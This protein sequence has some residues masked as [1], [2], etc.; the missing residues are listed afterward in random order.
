L[1]P[2]AGDPYDSQVD[3]TFDL[4]ERHHKTIGAGIGFQSD[5][6]LGL[7]ANWE[8]RNLLSQAE[9]L[10]LELLLAQQFQ[11]A[12][13]SFRKPHFLRDDQSLTLFSDLERERTDAFDS[14]SLEAGAEISRQFGNYLQGNIGAELT[15]S[16][17]EENNNSDNF[18]LASI[19]LSF[20]YDRRNDPLDPTSGWA[21]AVQLR[22]YLDAFSSGRQF[23][24]S[25]IAVS[26]YYTQ[27]HLKLRPTYAVRFAT[28]LINGEDRDD[29]PA[30]LRFFSG[31]G[32]SVRGYAFQSLGPF[33]DEDPAGG[34]SFTEISFESRLRIGANWGA[35]FFL[36][37][38]FAFTEQTPSAD[39]NI[40][41]GAGLGVRY[42]TNFAPIRF[43]IAAPLQPRGGVDDPFQIYISIGQSF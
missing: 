10:R 19:P 31:G 39:E 35:A 41:W 8:H 36:D 7:T 24:R 32:G 17:V 33:E 20:E 23:L 2:L 18:A 40:L 27:Q 42:Y 13:G 11:R 5:N 9:L 28:G 25:S 22:P 16:R 6:G 43:D 29:I 37:G 21:S 3:V 1:S 38:G 34:L 14:Q 30:N 12:S 15:F 26:G 4:H